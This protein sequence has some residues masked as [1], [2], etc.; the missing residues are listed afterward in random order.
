MAQIDNVGQ[1]LRPSKGGFALID[2]AGETTRL[3]G[4]L[5]ASGA[6]REAS[7]LVKDYG[8]NVMLMVLKRGARLHEHHTKGPLTV[9][10]IS[11]RVRFVAAGTPHDIAPGAMLALDREVGHSVEALEDSALLLTTAMG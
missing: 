9:Q 5:D 7:S 4:K 2:I 6:D 1:A 8:L 11:G 10:V 3:K